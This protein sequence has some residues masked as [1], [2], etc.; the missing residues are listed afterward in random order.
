MAQDDMS[1]PSTNYFKNNPEKLTEKEL[2]EIY[3][4]VDAAPLSRPKKNIMRDFSDCSLLAQIIRYY[5]PSSYKGIIQVH[6]Y[7][8]TMSTQQKY[9][10]WN[11]INQKVL[12]RFPDPY[13]LKKAGKLQ[14]TQLEIK[15]VVECQT[16]A[17]ERVLKKVKRALER[18]IQD[19]PEKLANV[20]KNHVIEKLAVTKEER[21]KKARL[22]DE[23]LK[24][25]AKKKGIIKDSAKKQRPSG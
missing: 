13:T 17:I 3:S 23:K 20:A 4:W 25:F 5:L 8:E 22:L 11:Q 2:E 19:P 6:N 15:C 10:N 7:V 16:G 9:N 18:F 12:S 14:L 1:Q 24:E 21:E